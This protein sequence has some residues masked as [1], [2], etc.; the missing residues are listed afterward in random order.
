MNISS[1]SP[2]PLP[3]R[4]CQLRS[5]TDDIQHH[6]EILRNLTTRCR[7]Y[8]LCKD[9]TRKLRASF[10]DETEV[11]DMLRMEFGQS[12]TPNCP[13]SDT[14]GMLRHIIRT[15]EDTEYFYDYLHRFWP[16][17]F[18]SFG[19]HL[20]D[21]HVRRWYDFFNNTI[22]YGTTSLTI[23]GLFLLVTLIGVVREDH[24]LLFAHATCSACII[25][26]ETFDPYASWS[27][28]NRLYCFA[29]RAVSA[30]QTDT[31][32]VER[33]YCIEDLVPISLI[34]ELHALSVPF[35][36]WPMVEKY[37]ADARSEETYLEGVTP[38]MED[39]NVESPIN[40]ETF[41]VTYCHEA[42]IQATKRPRCPEFGNQLVNWDHS[43]K[44]DSKVVVG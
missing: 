23:D 29:M 13:S 30:L 32:A 31:Q 44:S 25:F 20:I 27:K 17:R 37:D 14:S 40:K 8:R 24:F 5:V 36:L 4:P 38:M 12:W 2:P 1:A 22:L 15:I 26:Q 9:A 41:M 10:Q 39:Y 11:L 19:A 6:L 35:L 18:N 28:E 21:D 7:Y 43:P 16:Q 33:L 34:L 3:P 42:D